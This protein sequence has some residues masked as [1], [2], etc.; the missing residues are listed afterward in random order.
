VALASPPK[1]QR[2][3]DGRTYLLERALN[4]DFALVHATVADTAGNLIFHEANRNF[5]PL[6]AM[7]ARVTIAEA[8][9]IVPVGTIDPDRFHL[10]GIF[11]HRVIKVPSVYGEPTQSTTSEVSR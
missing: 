11:V 2:E 10:P 9:E 7:A 5:N 6:C 4:C 1:E 3:F 8:E